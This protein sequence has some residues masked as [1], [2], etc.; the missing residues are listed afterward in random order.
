MRTI[1]GEPAAKTAG[2]TKNLFAT[3]ACG[4]IINRT[5]GYEIFDYCL[6]PVVPRRAPCAAI[7]ARNR[8]TIRLLRPIRGSTDGCTQGIP[9][10]RYR[11]RTER[12]DRS[13]PRNPDHRG[14]W[15]EPAQ[16]GRRPALRLDRCGLYSRRHP[17][18]AGPHAPGL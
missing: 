15:N 14:E 4:A 9:P 17:G 12:A 2:A 8:T 11:H 7:E 1:P 10:G 6:L 3:G 18:P 5:L 13:R 16:A